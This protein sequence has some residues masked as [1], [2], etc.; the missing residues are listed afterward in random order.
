MKSD[1]SFTNTIVWNTLPLPQVSSDPRAEI[2]LA[3]QEV[4]KVRDETPN[5][6]LGMQYDPLKMKPKLIEAHEQLDELVCVAF[7]ADRHLATDRDRQRVLF[8]QYETVSA[9][10]LAGLTSGRTRRRTARS[11]S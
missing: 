4:L 2:I 5:L 10:L 9:G 1:P 8:E 6:P 3:G 11:G 7:G